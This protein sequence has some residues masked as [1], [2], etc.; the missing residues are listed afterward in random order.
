MKI[1][2]QNCLTK[3]YLTDKGT[4]DPA[5]AKAKVFDSSLKAYEHCRLHKIPDAQV[6]LKFNGGQFDVKLPVSDSC[7]EQMPR[8]NDAH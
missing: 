2:A 8:R 4:W 6:V 1:V 7:K 5:P 3:E